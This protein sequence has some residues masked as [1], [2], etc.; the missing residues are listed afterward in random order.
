M[1]KLSIILAG[2]SG[3]IAIAALGASAAKKSNDRAA[4]RGLQT[5]G[6]IVK[7][8][9]TNYVDTVNNDLAFRRA[10]DALLATVDPYTVYYPQENTEDIT[11]MTTGEYGGIGSYLLTRDGGSYISEPML[12]TPSQLAGLKAGDKI[13]KV[14]TID[15]SNQS[16]DRVSKLLRGKPNTQV[17]VQ[18]IR[19]YDTDSLKTFT[20][21]RAKLREKSVPFAGIINGNTGYIR[22]TQFIEKSGEEVRK[23]LEEFKNHPGLTGIILDL[24]GNGG[25]LLEQAVDIA[26]NFLPKGTEVVRTRGRD[27]IE[28]RVYKTTRT[29]IFAD[30]PLAVL[31]DGGTASASEI[32]AGAI[33]DLD[34][35]ILVGSRSFGKGLVQTTRPLP[36]G[37]VLKVTVARYYTPSGRLIQSLDYSH[38]NEDGSAA[39]VPDSLTHTF[40]TKAGRIMRDGGGLAPDT[41]I[42]WPKVNTLVYNIVRDNWVFDYATRYAA[43]HPSIPAP[44]NFTVTDSIYA[45]FSAS[46]DP[47]KFKY[48]DTMDKAV[49]QLRDIANEEGLLNEETTGT[50]D[51]LKEL[52]KHDLQRDLGINRKQVAEY[53]GSEIVGRYYYEPGRTEFLTRGDEAIDTAVGIMN[54]PQYRR[55]LSAPSASGKP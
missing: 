50:F 11:K 43:S 27:P 15:V 47:E 25:G 48:D 17:T 12:G 38:R 6:T 41:T 20:L 55:I 31:I 3:L 5:F 32:L 19:P 49:D 9:E 23:A 40:S 7:E 45:D 36:Y 35:G 1:K 53:L 34:R 18:V 54:S 44:G 51:R 26:S 14:D 22:L 13:V 10:I 33:Q 16:T 42:K 46:I 24:R 39:R 30:T 8:V 37:G 2:I 52:L 29:P 28:E 4:A 21:T